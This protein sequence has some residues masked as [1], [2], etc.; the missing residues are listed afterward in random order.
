MKPRTVAVL[1]AVLLLLA[2]CDPAGGRAGGPASPSRSTDSAPALEVARCMRANGFPDFPDPVRN[3]DGTWIF[4]ESAGEWVP[5]EPCRPLVGAWKRTISG[6]GI[7]PEEIAK[8]RDHARCMREHGIPDFP[9]PDEEGNLEIPERLRG[10]E[11]D[12]TLLAAKDACA[13]LLPPKRPK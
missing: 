13:S 1:G 9:D 10:L 4:P 6:K 5:P 11:N 3:D 2:G 8:I 7:T 12:P